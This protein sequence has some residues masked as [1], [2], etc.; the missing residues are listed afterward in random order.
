MC[1]ILMQQLLTFLWASINQ[2]RIESMFQNK[3]TQNRKYMWI[4]KKL[5]EKRK[6]IQKETSTKSLFPRKMLSMSTQIRCSLKKKKTWYFAGSPV[7][8]ALPSNA[9]GTDSN[10]GQGAKIP[11][12]SWPVKQDQHC[13]R[14]NK[15]F[16]NYPHKTSL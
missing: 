12:A 6:I 4:N 15:D 2:S 5:F 8:K 11:H 14:F 16:K 10:P 1:V 13:N 9:R 3:L 7:V